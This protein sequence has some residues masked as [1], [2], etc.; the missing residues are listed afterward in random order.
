MNQR[1][2]QFLAAENIS[3]AQFA[4]TIEV[5]RATV[6]HVIAGRN[7][8]GF[9]FIESISHHYPDLNIEWLITG[10]GKMYKSNGV[11]SI[12]ATQSPIQK[13]TSNDELFS[14][15]NESLPN[16]GEA[17]TS[18]IAAAESALRRAVEKTHPT[19]V[20]PARP[21][22]QEPASPRIAPKPAPSAEIR[23]NKG[24]RHISKIIVFYDD[25]S[26]QEVL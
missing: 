7:K 16:E 11:E 5:A 4:D 22:A 25:N 3:Q 24:E 2:L 26:F 17:I 1:I 21:A 14:F 18:E 13:N 12:A 19:A 10:K 6:S 15:E 8:P 9:D 20:Q 23:I